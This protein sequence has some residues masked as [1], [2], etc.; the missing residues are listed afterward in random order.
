MVAHQSPFLRPRTV[1]FWFGFDRKKK[2]IFFGVG[3]KRRG[4]KEDIFALGKKLEGPKSGSIDKPKQKRSFVF[5]RV[6]FKKGEEEAL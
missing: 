6:T 5:G 4:R 3:M 2:Q 1:F